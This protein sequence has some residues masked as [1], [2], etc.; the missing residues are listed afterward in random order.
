MNKKILLAIFAVIGLAVI[1]YAFTT[2]Q[3][4]I[5][6]IT[7]T[8]SSAL[9][10]LTIDDKIKEAQ[11]IVIGKVETTL[12]SKWKLNNDKDIKNASTQEIFNAEGLFTDSLISINQTLKGDNEGPIV[13]VRSYI[14]ETDQVRWV[15]SSEPS[16]KKGQV[17][18]LFLEKDIGPTAKVDPGDY[19]SVNSDTAVYEIVDGRAISANDE[20]DLAELITHI[21]NSLSQTP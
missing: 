16:F 20:W 10:A 12:P 2:K 4:K 6:I 9:R 19:I 14:G 3:S 18:L 7:F 21:Q 17:Y 13:R 8:E 15:N 1:F 5:E 11:L